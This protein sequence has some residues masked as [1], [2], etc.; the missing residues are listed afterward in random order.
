[1]KEAI[2]LDDYEETVKCRD[3]KDAACF[4]RNKDAS[5][6]YSLFRQKKMIKAEWLVDFFVQPGIIQVADQL[7]ELA[8]F[9][10][11]EKESKQYLCMP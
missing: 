1:M 4:S 7:R 10:L 9:Y 2:N 6:I 3:K 5:A 11:V 8:A